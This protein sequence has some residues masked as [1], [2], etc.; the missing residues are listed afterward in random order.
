[1]NEMHSNNSQEI[2]TLIT[3]MFWSTAKPLGL[4]TMLFKLVVGKESKI[5]ENQNEKVEIKNKLLGIAIK[6][7]NINLINTL[8]SNRTLFI[9]YDMYK[10]A[11]RNAFW[12]SLKNL[13]H[14]WSQLLTL[15][16]L[17]LELSQTSQ[18]KLQLGLANIK[19]YDY[20]VD[21]DY[22]MLETR[23]KRRSQ[24]KHENSNL[25]KSPR[26]ICNVQVLSLH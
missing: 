26:I 18:T 7:E 14:C 20:I 25:W 22:P 4:F 2:L 11:I 3:W 24:C 1:M 10:F 5:Y 12:L 17:K 21:N 6:H 16:N 23:F 13:R 8:I 9:S 15:Q 19:I